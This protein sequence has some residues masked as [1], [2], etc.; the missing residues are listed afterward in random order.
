M[1]VRLLW[2]LALFCLPTALA[3]QGL[4]DHA[5]REKQR[6]EAEKK[7]EPASEYVYTQHDLEQYRPVDSDDDEDDEGDPDGDGEG[8]TSANDEI[9]EEL[10]RMRAQRVRGR[11]DPNRA[12]RD[13]ASR[14]QSEVD[15]IERRMRELNGKL[16]PMSRDYIYGEANTGSAANQ[17]LEI[18][19]ELAELQDDL[20]QAQQDLVDANAELAN[21]T[22]RSDY[23]PRDEE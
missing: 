21:A 4:G 14:A 3:A 13:E 22:G 19:Q 2:A 9:D 7:A 23:D 16:N 15:Q 18:K 17:E 6:R 11:N 20:R 8:A 10:R 12:Q 1:I 5:A